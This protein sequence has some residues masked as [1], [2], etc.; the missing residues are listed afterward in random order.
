[1]K[2]VNSFSKIPQLGRYAPRIL[3]VAC[4]VLRLEAEMRTWFPPSKSSQFNAGGRKPTARC[5]ITGLQRR[6][7]N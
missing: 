3:I 4:T 7:G 5:S 6:E 1:M 2:K